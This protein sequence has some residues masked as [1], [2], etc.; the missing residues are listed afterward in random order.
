MTPKVISKE[1]L[2]EQMAFRELNHGDSIKIPLFSPI[3]QKTLTVTLDGA[4]KKP[5]EYSFIEGTTLHQIIAQA[6]GYTNDAYPYGASLF[7]K[8]VARSSARGI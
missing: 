1:Y 7:R 6:G 5:G 8:K 4:V 3:T 2:S